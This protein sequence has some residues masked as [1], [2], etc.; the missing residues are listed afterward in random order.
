MNQ[1]LLFSNSRLKNRQLT[2]QECKTVLDVA[3]FRPLDPIFCPNCKTEMVVPAKLGIY[4]L[5]KFLGEGAMGR[6]YLARDP[7]LKRDVAIKLLREDLNATPK[8][9]T[10]LENEAKAAAAITHNNVIHIY[11]MGKVLGRPYIV[12]EVADFASLDDVLEEEGQIDEPLAIQ[13]SI[14]VMKGLRAAYK[15]ELIHGDIKP[16]NI[17]ITHKGHAKVADF[18]LARFLKQGQQVERWG[19]PYYIAPE[20]SKQVSEDF[21]SDLYSLGATLF[22]AIAGHAPFEGETGEEVIAKSLKLNTP[23][24]KKIC[25]HTSAAFSEL[26]YIMMQ[27]DPN[28]RFW[29]Y[30][31]AI[32]CFEKLQEGSYELGTCKKLKIGKNAK[33][34]KN[35]SL[36]KKIS[37]L[38][39]DHD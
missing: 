18:G 36:I 14:D 1:E 8:M 32:T 2:C 31:Q 3:S 10:L 16:A 28:E 22:H 12:M 37:S 21:R 33:R 7:I 19:T 29:S 25:P 26:V 13:I 38:V 35:K 11:T 20:K 15:N 6:V 27:R 17:L 23:Q 30:N 5:Y 34:K 39:M 9:W 4:D 24:L